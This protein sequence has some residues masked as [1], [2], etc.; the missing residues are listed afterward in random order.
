MPPLVNSDSTLAVVGAG[1]SGLVVART[2]QNT[3]AS[4][5]LFDKGRQVAGRMSTR[6]TEVA[7]TFDHGAQYFTVR[8]PLFESEI[9][10]WIEKGIVSDWKG[11]IGALCNGHFKPSIQTQN[12]FVG[13]PGMNQL[14]SCLAEDLSLHSNIVVSEAKRVGEAWQLTDQQAN[15]LGEFDVMI[16]ST[17]APQAAKLLETVPDLQL[18]A[19]SIRMSPCWAVML[20]FTDTLA[21]DSDGA[22]VEDSP[23]SWIACNSSKPGRSTLPETWVLHASPDWSEQHLEDS[24]DSVLEDLIAA[25]WQATQTASRQ[26]IYSRAHRWRFSLPAEPL[27]EPFLLNEQMRIAACGD[28]CGGPRVE[29]AFLSG[30]KLAERLLGDY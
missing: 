17:P 11:K 16:V 23:L 29:G 5:T 19:A 14:C 21:L 10:S 27:E 7:L 28:W 20:A 24:A 13:V 6:R 2:L 12:R 3:G 25:F 4:V 30:A 8:D 26:P 1:V 18:R 9:S 15:S 22:F